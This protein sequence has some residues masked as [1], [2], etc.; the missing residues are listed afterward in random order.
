MYLILR[1]AR[2]AA[3]YG[4]VKPSGTARTAPGAA[5]QDIACAAPRRRI[6]EHQARAYALSCAVTVREAVRSSRQRLPDIIYHTMPP[7]PCH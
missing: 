7:G 1:L 4:H 6:S 5:A 3:A 2:T